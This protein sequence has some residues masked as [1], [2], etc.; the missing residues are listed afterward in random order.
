[1][2]KRHDIWR[3]S[4]I[5]TY[6]VVTPYE[7]KKPPRPFKGT[8]DV[9]FDKKIA[10]RLEAEAAAL[11]GWREAYAS[12]HG[13]ERLAE[14]EST[15]DAFG[16]GQLVLHRQ[17]GYGVVTGVDSL[18]SK[19]GRFS[20]KFAGAKKSKRLSFPAVF[21]DE[22]VSFVA[23]DQALRDQYGLH[24]FEPRKN[25]KKQK[26]VDLKHVSPASNGLSRGLRVRHE[27]YGEGR[28]LQAKDDVIKVR[29]WNKEVKH[30]R[31]E[32]FLRI[33]QLEVVDKPGSADF[34]EED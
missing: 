10:P 9:R 12:E 18:Y 28:V 17:Y 21:Y 7:P 30:F 23:E 20:V 31:H 27:V 6:D 24:L 11:Q 3:G 4:I 14:L 16:K 26:P 22:T 8:V 19:E 5:E 34:N 25:T 15:M 2:V 1:M 13:E 33:E 29:F 32:G